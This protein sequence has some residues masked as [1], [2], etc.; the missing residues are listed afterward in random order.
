[1]DD[2]TNNAALG[3]A[4]AAAAAAAGGA[5]T[6]TDSTG[7]GGRARANTTLSAHGIPDTGLSMASLE[8]VKEFRTILKQSPANIKEG[9]GD[10]FASVLSRLGDTGLLRKLTAP[11]SVGKFF[12][13]APVT[14][15]SEHTSQ[16]ILKQVT[17]KD[18]SFEAS[19]A[20]GVVEH[21]QSSNLRETLAHYSRKLVRYA[22]LSPKETSNLI[23][24]QVALLQ[25][26]HNLVSSKREK[27]ATSTKV[28]PSSAE[29]SSASATGTS[30]ALSTRS[31]TRGADVSAPSEEGVKTEEA[32]TDASVSVADKVPKGARVVPDHNYRPETLSPGT[33][34][35]RGKDWN[36]TDEADGGLGYGEVVEMTNWNDE[37]NKGVVVKWHHSGEDQP[38]TKSYRWGAQSVSGRP[39][40]EVAVAEILPPVEPSDWQDDIC[41]WFCKNELQPTTPGEKEES[42]T[43]GITA[44]KLIDALA[45]ASRSCS[46]GASRHSSVSGQSATD[47]LTSLKGFRWE[48]K[49][50]R[51]DNGDGGT[52]NRRNRSKRRP[53]HSD[54]GDH[55]SSH[56]ATFESSSGPFQAPSESVFHTTV[57]GIFD[58]VIEK[59]LAENGGEKWNPQ[60]EVEISDELQEVSC[61][62][63]L[64]YL[65]LLQRHLLE[66]LIGSLQTSDSHASALGSFNVALTPWIQWWHLLV[67][68]LSILTEHVDQTVTGY[69]KQAEIE[70]GKL[71][72]EFTEQQF[73]SVLKHL[74][75]SM[76][77]LSNL[78]ETGITDM[79]HPSITVLSLGT[80][81]ASPPEIRHKRVQ[82]HD[83]GSVVSEVET[84]LSTL[85]FR[86]MKCLQFCISS[87][88]EFPK[89][90]KG[91]FKLHE[92]ANKMRECLVSLG[93]VLSSRNSNGAD[94]CESD[95]SASKLAE[96]LVY[97]GSV[98]DHLAEDVSS[99]SGVAKSGQKPEG[100]GDVSR[101]V[102]ELDNEEN[103]GNMVDV[104]CHGLLSDTVTSRFASTVPQVFH[105]RSA[106]DK[107]A[108]AL[109]HT[110]GRLGHVLVTSVPHHQVEDQSETK[111]WLRSCVVSGGLQGGDMSRSDAL[112][113]WLQ[114]LL[115]ASTLGCADW[116]WGRWQNC[117]LHRKRDDL[118]SSTDYSS[119]PEQKLS[120]AL[121]L[122]FKPPA[123]SRE[124]SRKLAAIGRSNV[125]AP[126]Q[127]SEIS[128]LS[129]SKLIEAF[130][131]SRK[132]SVPLPESIQEEL[133]VK[134]MEVPLVSVAGLWMDSHLGGALSGIA[135]RRAR[136]RAVEGWDG[137]SVPLL[138]EYATPFP[139]TESVFL[140][141]LLHHVS[142][143]STVASTDRDSIMGVPEEMLQGISSVLRV[144]S[145]QP[146]EL[147]ALYTDHK[148]PKN[149]NS[150]QVEASLHHV[151]HN[152][153]T[154]SAAIQAAERCLASLRGY[155]WS[156]RDYAKSGMLEK[157]NEVSLDEPVA[158]SK[159]KPSSRSAAAPSSETASGNARHRRRGRSGSSQQQERPNSSSSR[160]KQSDA[161]PKLL[162]IEAPTSMAEVCDS[163]QERCFFMLSISPARRS[164]VG[165]TEN[166][167]P[168][169]ETSTPHAGKSMKPK[170]VE[171]T[172]LLS[173]WKSQDDAS[174]VMMMS[175][176]Q[177]SQGST[178]PP[179]LSLDSAQV[180]VSSESRS[181][182]MHDR[183]SG[184]S[185]SCGAVP[186]IG[187]NRLSWISSMCYTCL[188]YAKYG[189]NV[190]PRLL[191][192]LLFVRQ[193]RAAVR[194]YGLTLWASVLRTIMGVDESREPLGSGSVSD[195][196]GVEASQPAATV[197]TRWFSGKADRLRIVREALLPARDSLGDSHRYCARGG[198]SN[199]IQESVRMKHNYLNNLEGVS[200]DSLRLVQSAWADMYVGVSAILAVSAHVGD[201]LTGA[202]CL[203]CWS[204]DLLRGDHEMLSRSGV[205]KLISDLASA[206]KESDS[207]VETTALLSPIADG[208]SGGGQASGQAT[209]N[210]RQD[211]GPELPPLDESW[212][213]MD[214]E[215]V[216]VALESGAMQVQQVV[217][218]IKGFVNTRLGR[219]NRLHEIGSEA[220]ADMFQSTVDELTAIQQF[221][222]SR[223]MWR[224]AREL[225]N[226]F[227]ANT[228]IPMFQ[229]FTE[230]VEETEVQEAQRA[231]RDSADV[232]MEGTENAEEAPVDEEKKQRE[233]KAQ[234]MREKV[235]KIHQLLNKSWVLENDFLRGAASEL[236]R[237]LICSVVG[238]RRNA[239]AGDSHSIF[240]QPS[241][242][243]GLKLNLTSRHK[244]VL[245]DAPPSSAAA[246][247]VYSEAAAS[248]VSRHCSAGEEI[249]GANSS[250]WTR[251][252]RETVVDWVTK[253]IHF[254]CSK[255]SEHVCEDL[256]NIPDMMAALRRWERFERIV[257]EHMVWLAAVRNTT[258]V[259]Q[260]FHPTSAET[261]GKRSPG[262]FSHLCWRV[263]RFGSLRLQQLST[264]LLADILPYQNPAAATSALIGSSRWSSN[265]SGSHADARTVPLFLLSLIGSMV[266]FKYS[267]FRQGR[268]KASIPVVDFQSIDELLG[269]N[270]SSG[271]NKDSLTVSVMGGYRCGH[272][273]MSLASLSVSLLRALIVG[274]LRWERVCE[275]LFGSIFEC[276]NQSSGHVLD[277]K[278]AKS[279]TLMRLTYGATAVLGGFTEILRP[280]IRAIPAS[281]WK[282]GAEAGLWSSQ[283]L[284]KHYSCRVVKFERGNNNAW[285]LYPPASESGQARSEGEVSTPAIDTGLV[286]GFH[287]MHPGLESRK[288]ASSSLTPLDNPRL[289][290]EQVS[291]FINPTLGVEKSSY[292]QFIYQVLSM[293]AEVEVKS[294][295]EREKVTEQ[296]P[297]SSQIPSNSFRVTKCGQLE[298][299]VELKHAENQHRLALLIACASRAIESWISEEPSGYPVTTAVVNHH[300]QNARNR[301]LLSV[302]VDLSARPLPQYRLTLP[303]HIV[304]KGNI[305][306]ERLLDISIGDSAVGYPAGKSQSSSSSGDYDPALI[307]RQAAANEISLMGFDYDLALKGLEIKG[308][309][310]SRV[311]EW[312][313]SGEAEAF[314]SGGG[315]EESSK[316]TENDLRYE[317]ARNLAV[318]VGKPPRLC[319]KALELC[320][321][322]QNSALNWI[323]DYG[324]TFMPGL[325]EELQT[326]DS[327]ELE[328]HQNRLLG[329][330]DDRAVLHDLGLD[331]GAGA[332]RQTMQQ[333]DD[334]DENESDGE[335]LAS[336]GFDS[337]SEDDVGEDAPLEDYDDEEHAYGDEAEDEEEEEE[338][339]EEEEH[340]GDEMMA[341]EGDEDDGLGR[342]IW[343]AGSPG[344]RLARNEETAEEDRD[345]EFQHE[346]V[347][348]HDEE[349]M[350][351]AGGADGGAGSM[352]RLMDQLQALREIT[353]N[354]SNRERQWAPAVWAQGGDEDD[355]AGGQWE[356]EA[357]NQEE[358]REQGAE[359]DISATLPSLL[360]RRVT[361]AVGGRPGETMRDSSTITGRGVD[362]RRFM[363][364]FLG[365][366]AS[367]GTGDVGSYRGT[368]SDVQRQRHDAFTVDDEFLGDTF[369]CRAHQC[370]APQA[371]GCDEVQY[372]RPASV[373]KLGEAR[374]AR[375]SKDLEVTPCTLTGF[376]ACLFSAQRHDDVSINS[377]WRVQA[378]T[379][380]ILG[381]VRDGANPHLLIAVNCLHTGS[382]KYRIASRK[383]IRLHASIFGVEINSDDQNCALPVNSVSLATQMSCTLLSSR[384][385]LINTILQWPSEGASGSASWRQFINRDCLLNLTRYTVATED[386]LSSAETGSESSKGTSGS[387]L[388]DKIGAGVAV[389][390]GGKLCLPLGA[391]CV[392]AVLLLLR[393]WMLWE[394]SQRSGELT[395]LL[396]D[397]VATNIASATTP[398]ASEEKPVIRESLHPHFNQCEVHD[399]VTIPGAR[400]LWVTFD[401]RSQLGIGGGMMSRARLRFQ[402]GRTGDSGTLEFG[403]DSRELRPFVVHGD[404]LS[405][406]FST[407]HNL[408]DSG[409][410][411]RM[412]ISPMQ[413]LAWRNEVSIW[414]SEPSLEWACWLMEFLL[415]HSVSDSDE[416]S[417]VSSSASSGFAASDEES[418]IV[419]RQQ[420]SQLY[421]GKVFQALVRYLQSRGTPF[422]HRVIQLVSQI[423]RRTNMFP[424]GDVPDF[425][426]L[427]GME[428]TVMETCRNYLREPAQTPRPGLLSL[429]ELLTTA[430][431]AE[432]AIS[433]KEQEKGDIQRTA[434]SLL[435]ESGEQ[436]SLIDV[437]SAVSVLRTFPS[438]LRHHFTT[439]GESEL[440]L[441]DES[442]RGIA[443]R[444][445]QFVLLETHDLLVALHSQMLCY[446]EER[447]ASGTFCLP[448]PLLAR[449]VVS[450]GWATGPEDITPAM[451]LR[452]AKSLGSWSPVQDDQLVQWTTTITS[453]GRR[454]KKTEV[455][456]T[457]ANSEY[458]FD[459]CRVG[460]A[461]S[462]LELQ[463]KTLKMRSPTSVAPPDKKK[464]RFKHPAP[465]LPDDTVV[466]PSISGDHVSTS[467]LRLRFA[468]IQML[469][470][471]L[472]H[473][474]PLIDTVPSDT[475]SSNTDSRI[476]QSEYSSTQSLGQRLRESAHLVFIDVKL[477]VL[478]KA[479]KSTWT[480]RRG[481]GFRVRIDN[482]AAFVSRDKAV[483]DES[484]EAR[485]I[486][487]SKCLFVQLYQGLHKSASNTLRNSPE[488][489]GGTESA[490]VGRVLAR[491]LRAHLDPRESLF[492]VE[493]TGEDGMDWGGLY[494]DCLTRALDDLFPSSIDSSL[495][496]S[497]RVPVPSV[498]LFIPCPN[499]MK[500]AGENTDKWVPNA[501]HTSPLALSMFR[502]VGRLMGIALRHKSYLPFDVAPLIW[503]R[504]IQRP[505]VSS[506]K[507]VES[508]E[509]GYGSTPLW[510]LHDTDSWREL[511]DLINLS[512]KEFETLYPGTQSS[513]NNDDESVLYFVFRD[514]D[515][516]PLE[517]CNGGSNRRVVTAQDR[518]EYFKLACDVREREFDAQ[519]S[520][521]RK[522]LVSIVPAR[523]L[524]L[525]TWR[526]L[527]LMVCGDPAVDVA[528]LKQNTVYSGFSAAEQE[529]YVERFWRVFESLSKEEQSSFIRFAW[530][531][532]RLPKPENWNRPFKLMRRGGGDTDLPVSHACFFSVEMPCYSSD[533][534]A[535]Q[536]I[537]TAIH[538]G[539]GGEFLIA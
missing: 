233:G 72:G 74:E 223:Q 284:A 227:S 64:S 87:F 222:I 133:S 131:Q 390:R 391:P 247:S 90:L 258:E 334:M 219:S 489:E 169:G 194:S 315:L 458:D 168:M 201:S 274:S 57:K 176:H 259:K 208:E 467:D 404:T 253:Q 408:S 6:T 206:N 211:P 455:E 461:R 312:F 457:Y 507:L 124:E 337:E 418:I 295:E 156:Q 192:P 62:G 112:N 316:E 38:T 3:D 536:R 58:K 331:S 383:Q 446:M 244:A 79:L 441:P 365:G 196:F 97:S 163:I 36:P 117:D 45:F 183:T 480:P 144:I 243:T 240:E 434:T 25:Y 293:A 385:A 306:L 5:G 149:M 221:W 188:N 275:G 146:G 94:S 193:I 520:A 435:N 165:Y 303:R 394:G 313:L 429:V 104:L 448:P 516:K 506:S 29:S 200:D 271:G 415:R 502:F 386:C 503:A 92:G 389:G 436:S 251:W 150:P 342:N 413:G 4:N 181:A 250:Y 170:R 369:L 290:P 465:G 109:S 422:K 278:T 362:V 531:R 123:L 476:D 491:G 102:N 366:D 500:G 474:C 23:E 67:D 245:E 330:V 471:R 217:D 431:S 411:Y 470:K 492:K 49:R 378:E 463:P 392:G 283:N 134:L 414:R 407:R 356:T 230:A 235:E 479:V 350:E 498:D 11:V 319:M 266:S 82:P 32:N 395:S 260:W 426:L 83:T 239:D 336:H 189:H 398:H 30:P 443:A 360:F 327:N 473:V 518:R 158:A 517:L 349:E 272:H 270:L 76:G 387:A 110:A 515:G 69:M 289:S 526:E 521:M 318:M 481:S 333:F 182:K 297:S 326:I 255:L 137:V 216:G 107:T 406:R 237:F 298:E 44:E 31:R 88:V 147:L 116:F 468:V 263:F 26:M 472:N 496:G 339:D 55:I 155:L 444:P 61:A 511:Q 373:E 214:R 397:N 85:S 138:S 353:R 68:T 354:N 381:S 197:E 21:C 40:Y 485:S 186:H 242:V 287:T 135:K 187:K 382:V 249:G 417:Q 368:S 264:V 323:M 478:D 54:E 154:P 351:E 308:D 15:L 405:Y 401:P 348:E 8:E 148:G 190:P 487:Q 246:L 161:A 529:E 310:K 80:G 291:R 153:V 160:S 519:C 113:S 513:G 393:E 207:E 367:L 166:D 514:S 286:S 300:T 338:D 136:S 341:N 267:K 400:A 371:G 120:C 269:L 335:E 213:M 14:S 501:S 179:P 462:P 534:I 51:N 464:K 7:R 433:E 95:T 483:H 294:V 70:V 241:N 173:R 129:P 459:P 130:K 142:A 91:W 226:T 280:G 490:A 361:A 322:D 175:S 118:Q 320:G 525:L 424:E 164:A 122:A 311:V 59:F 220:Q 191:L 1:M 159:P 363:Q 410:G 505:V 73:Q 202:I 12:K 215:A 510:A 105:L 84:T 28:I 305:C 412:I 288:V 438:W 329:N 379:G 450:A 499:Q 449:A 27:G 16:N 285:V 359:G 257:H 454:A 522:G 35:V 532:A 18:E 50:K 482:N 225:S 210:Q 204:V 229:E 430:R 317:N 340:S 508:A 292:L 96:R 279:E 281:A 325:S 346:D 523:A 497:S 17:L 437:D 403:G 162:K 114:P 34:V 47:T 420:R 127:V 86:G 65:R 528:L 358:R 48:R 53:K 440:S 453:P 475:G 19:L 177:Q 141:S 41:A 157:S 530:G 231:S 495:P 2:H 402:D 22:L 370:L 99:L 52:P 151:R 111:A 195:A 174:K 81:L 100:L 421:S 198:P 254:A 347:E 484:G 466:F 357:G 314:K 212:S 232:Q 299:T 203:W 372:R 63:W 456:Q 447:K 537:R 477:Q 343:L 20:A 451:L 143:L 199:A 261:G 355:T 380:V 493:Y 509:E 445:V 37:E 256:D 396:V 504:I 321:D 375:I 167:A 78:F 172:P 75:N 224:P 276:F 352:S 324:D 10:I 512:Q 39:L 494:R 442:D 416:H 33:L 185:V 409:W 43:S 302:L 460:S 93:K 205:L 309:D 301:S 106:V 42:Q 126:L 427:R 282:A 384:R 452:A 46:S 139:E 228:M 9:Q 423:L 56:P 238:G 486:T 184:E 345:E 119:L 171:L 234:K 377:Q 60:G 535:R 98:L 209:N 121:P 304:A 527:E 399:K 145:E 236:Y 125:K 248:T 488:S 71:D 132:V 108:A 432:R 89:L 218:H 374:T 439:F 268:L 469:N 66:N 296:A 265:T 262:G 128:R 376:V 273:V 13:A 419:P 425:S 388:L 328:E 428:K 140:A 101:E 332:T 539:A 277:D 103:W 307:A 152:T 364:E 538:F 252:L 180:N 533:E 344:V 77:V 524:Q 178:E 115:D 24:R